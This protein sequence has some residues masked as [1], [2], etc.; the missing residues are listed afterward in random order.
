[1]LNADE[2]RRG[3]WVYFTHNEKTEFYKV[4]GSTIWH[5]DHLDNMSH[6]MEAAAISAIPLTIELLETCGFLGDESQYGGWLSPLA[7]GWGMRIR[8]NG[9]GE[10]YY[11]P[12]KYSKPIY[13]KHLH[14]LQ[15][16]YF[17]LTQKEL[18]VNLLQPA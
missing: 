18:T 13:V 4:R 1:M 10:F 12:D 11:T 14:Q 6:S 8:V 16:L 3:N 9:F 17:A 7:D 5:F 15:N 2:L